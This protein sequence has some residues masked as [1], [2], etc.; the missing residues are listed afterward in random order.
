[1][2]GKSQRPPWLGEDHR[3][4]DHV[5]I[6]VQLL[7]DERLG[8]FHLAVYMGLA[9]HADIGTGDARPAAA[10]LGSYANMSE[11]TARRAMDELAGWGYLS[12]EPRKGTASIYR[13]LPP[14]PLPEPRTESPTLRVDDPGQRNSQRRTHTTRTPDTGSDE[15]EP[16]TRLNKTTPSAAEAA[17]EDVD[18]FGA[19]IGV[20]V[21]DPIK[22]QAHRV[23]VAVFEQRFP[24]PATPFPGVMGVARSLIAA[25]H[26][27][28]AVV[29]AMVED[30]ALTI[31]A[32][33]F[34]LGRAREANGQA[35]NRRGPS[36]S[37]STVSLANWAGRTDTRRIG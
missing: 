15:Q 27:P 1:M 18:L 21:A 3:T 28:G 34:R 12:V 4:W 2:S 10:T 37:K 17:D 26:D 30:G 5:R 6:H 11:R 9:M 13:L 35:E 25:G 32:V 19:P 31:A 16:R 29:D 24:R 7:R 33:E 22:D 23:A 8:A 14:P 20:P 36:V